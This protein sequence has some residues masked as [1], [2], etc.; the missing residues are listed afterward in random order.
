MPCR[1]SRSTLIVPALRSIINGEAD[2]PGERRVWIALD[3]CP[4]LPGRRATGKRGSA[5]QGSCLRLLCG[6]SLLGNRPYLAI[7]IRSL[8][9]SR[10][11]LRC[12]F[13]QNHDI[14]REASRTG[15]DE[16]R[17]TKGSWT[18]EPRRHN[19]NL[20]S[21]THFS[22][23]I[24]AALKMAKDQGRR[25]CGVQLNGYDSPETWNGCQAWWM[26]TCRTSSTAMTAWPSVSA[27][28]LL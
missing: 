18:S 27:R 25:Y 23:G 17:L 4:L 13:C 1:N 24:A 11:N 28:V 3:C 2:L 6:T 14:S 20:V 19:V 12:V 10:C 5:R 15:M 22:H 8:F 16:E 9:F 21:P 7:G 26:C